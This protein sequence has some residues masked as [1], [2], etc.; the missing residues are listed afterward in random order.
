MTAGVFMAIVSLIVCYEAIA[1]HIFDSPTTWVMSVSL[2]AFMWFPFLSSPYGIKEDKHVACDVFVSML[3]KRTRQ[4]LGIF[5]DLTTLIFIISL[6]YFGYG[7]FIE[8]YEFKSMS[9]GLIRYPLWIL[10]INNPRE[11]VKRA[12]D[13]SRT[14]CQMQPS[15]RRMGE[16]KPKVSRSTIANPPA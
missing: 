3:H 7:H 9:A 13:K 4:W 14:P 5:T 16:G 11:L 1:R 6:G 10:R 12:V 15:I 2:F 8:A